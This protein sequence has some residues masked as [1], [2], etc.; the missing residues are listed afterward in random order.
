MIRL[1]AILLLK[2]KSIA[3]LF[4]AVAISNNIVLLQNQYIGK[5]L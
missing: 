5:I 3:F 1:D 2:Y 4:I